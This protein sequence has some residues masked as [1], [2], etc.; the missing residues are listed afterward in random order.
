LFAVE[1]KIYTV[2][3][4]ADWLKVHNKT[5]RR[6]IMAGK[7]RAYRVGGQEQSGSLRVRE[8]DLLF[9]LEERATRPKPSE[10][11]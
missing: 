11:D 5:V 7:L 9:F 1:E 8:S 6:W 4:I 10:E 2:E 3:E